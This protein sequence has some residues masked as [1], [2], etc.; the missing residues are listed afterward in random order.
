MRTKQPIELDLT[1]LLIRNGTLDYANFML[2]MSGLLSDTVPWTNIDGKY[3]LIQQHPNSCI[4]V[5]PIKP[6]KQPSLKEIWDINDYLSYM[7]EIPSLP[8]PD[9]TSFKDYGYEFLYGREL[10]TRTETIHNL[11]TGEEKTYIR[12]PPSKILA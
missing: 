2:S 11:D 5:C 4:Y 12:K 7:N 9:E 6:N 3:Q 10:A 1:P 8:I